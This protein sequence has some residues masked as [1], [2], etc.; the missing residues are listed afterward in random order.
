[1]TG[2]W[3]A[4]LA[5][6]LTHPHTFE[7]MLSPALA[8]LR[9]EAAAG[10]RTR[11]AHY[12]GLG[13]VLTAAIR[14][15]WCAD[16]R[17]A[18][19]RGARRDV[20]V[21]SGIWY[22]ALTTLLAGLVLRQQTPWHLLDASTWPAVV[23]QAVLAPRL[24]ASYIAAAAAA[25]LLSR[26]LSAFKAVVIG[27]VTI[28]VAVVAVNAVA[29]LIRTPLNTAIHETARRHLAAAPV[30]TGDPS[31][32]TDGR[33]SAWLEARGAQAARPAT[34]AELA[35]SVA[36]A[37][38]VTVFN[39]LPFALMGAALA[40]SRG[41][42]VAAGLVVVILTAIAVFGWSLRVLA[43]PSDVVTHIAFMGSILLGASLWAVVG[44]RISPRK[45]AP[46]FSPA[47]GAGRQ[48]AE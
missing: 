36:M 43:P 11:L 47:S 12:A 41:W 34:A 26:R 18:F 39:F 31:L 40:R 38:V 10:W 46:A 23:L 45:A 32:S 2:H 16:T 24:Y 21:V 13:V 5:R 1:M 20:W 8:D 44:P 35:Q 37:P 28:T 33:W 7:S 25:F 4:A 6:R 48:S 14:R 29:T 27:A 42:G 19:E 9:A 3:F 17:A 30:A 22:V 15:D